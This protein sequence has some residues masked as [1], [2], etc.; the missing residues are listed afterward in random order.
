M[1]NHITDNFRGSASDCRSDD[2]QRYGAS[3]ARDSYTHGAYCVA[4]RR[5]DR[6]SDSH[7]DKIM[8]ALRSERG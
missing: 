6:T 2:G 4:H 1:N 3:S 7:F 5:L 8:I